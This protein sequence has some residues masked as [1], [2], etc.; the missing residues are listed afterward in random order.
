MIA[1]DHQDVLLQLCIG[2]DKDAGLIEPAGGT[3][4]DA[5]LLHK[6]TQFSITKTNIQN[7]VLEKFRAALCECENSLLNHSSS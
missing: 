4:R 6:S 2:L 5:Y 3:A 1:L 7:E